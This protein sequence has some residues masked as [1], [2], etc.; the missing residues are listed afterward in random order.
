MKTKSYKDNNLVPK[1]GDKV[2]FKNG[3]QF[4]NL[5]PS[6]SQRDKLN[7]TPDVVYVV[8]EIEKH[9]YRDDTFGG[10][11]TDRINYVCTIKHNDLT[12]QCSSDWLEKVIEEVEVEE[13]KRKEE[14][15]KKESTTIEQDMMEVL[16]GPE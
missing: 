15:E 14:K 13:K 9:G 11:F 5:C 10:R 6:L 12:E 3:N 16:I 4:A 2:V 8:E 1:I 7:Y